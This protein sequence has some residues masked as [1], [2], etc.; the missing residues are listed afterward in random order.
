MALMKR[1]WLRFV[2]PGLAAWIVLGACGPEVTSLSACENAEV[3]Q[4]ICEVESFP[5]EN[6]C[7][8]DMTD[9]D[10]CVAKCWFRAPCKDLVQNLAS[11][12]VRRCLD[13]CEPD[14]SVENFA[15]GD[16]QTV[17]RD[18]VCDGRYDC[19]NRFDEE[20]CVSMPNEPSPDGS[21]AGG[22]NAGGSPSDG[23]P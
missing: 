13:D 19:R 11:S 3:K 2:T 23:G 16:G 14:E 12:D 4:R 22:S 5:V 9:T 10:R 20:D 15:C 8:G 17:P 7:S 18:W 21:A 6:V 1:D